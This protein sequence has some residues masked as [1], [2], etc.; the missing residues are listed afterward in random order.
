MSPLI[1]IAICESGMLDNLY[2]DVPMHSI[3]G[4]L[5]HHDLVNFYF[6]CKDDYKAYKKDTES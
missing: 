3:D 5:L 2:D 4:D 6:Q 1:V